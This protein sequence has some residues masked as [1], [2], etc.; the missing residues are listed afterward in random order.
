MA[1]L[2]SREELGRWRAWRRDWFAAG[3]PERDW[4]AD[5]MTLKIQRA[6]SSC[7][8]CM[9]WLSGKAMHALTSR[10]R[11]TWGADF[12]ADNFR[13]FLHQAQ[14]QGP[15]PPRTRWSLLLLALNEWN[16]GD[17]TR[18]YSSPPMPHPLCRWCGRCP[19]SLSHWFK[20]PCEYLRA[21]CGRFRRGRLLTPAFAWEVDG[22]CNLKAVWVQHVY[23]IARLR[24]HYHDLDTPAHLTQEAMWLQGVVDQVDDRQ[25]TRRRQAAKSMRRTRERRRTPAILRCR[26]GAPLLGPHVCLLDMLGA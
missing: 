8:R 21:E 19:E 11:R 20:D 15:I 23:T 2:G 24:T 1:G 3:I 12:S 9:D 22:L 7:M 16:T 10:G 18:H 25:T 6:V 4:G 14:R 13:A 17:R 26:C 5:A